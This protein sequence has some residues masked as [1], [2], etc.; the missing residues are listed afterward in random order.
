MVL[1]DPSLLC[2]GLDKLVS[3]T[4]SGNK[5]PSAS[6]RIA[7]FRLERQ[8][9][10]RATAVD[11]EDYA[12]LI[13]GELEAAQLAQPLP[14]QPK[15]A[16]LD[17]HPST[18]DDKDKDRD[19][20]KGK[21]KGKKPCWGWQDGTGCRFGANCLFL[22]A[23]LGP[24]RCWECGSESHLKPQCPLLGQGGRASGGSGGGTTG[25]GKGSGGAAQSANAQNSSTSSTAATTGTAT[26]EKPPRKPKRKGGGKDRGQKDAVRK[27]EEEPLADEARPTTSGGNVEDA[28]ARTEF[29]EE[30][31][32]ALKSLRLAKLTMRSLQ[33]SLGGGGRALIDS[34]ATTS[35]RTAREGEVRGLPLRTV[36]L[37]EGETTFYQLP[38]GTLLTTK[39][40]APIVAMSDL[41]EIGCRVTWCSSE[42]C[43]VVHPVKGDL[44]AR[45]VNGCPEVDE[46]VG[47]KLIE[48][49]ELTKLRRREAELAVNRLVQDCDAL[50][51][52][53]GKL[54]WELGAKAAKDLGNGVGLSW[55][56]LRQAFPEAPSWLV[57]AVPVVAEMDGAGVPWN[58]HERKKWRRAS[59]V[60]VHLFCGRDRST[61]K[62]RA[63]AAHVVLV[64]QAEDVMADA[65]YSALLEL[66]ASGKL[67]T[68]F[69]GPPCRTFSALRN[70]PTAGAGEGPRPLRDREGDGRWG[71]QG[72]TEWETWRVRQDTIMVFRMIFLWMVAAATARANGERDPDFILEHPEDPQTFLKEQNM[73][74]LWAFPEIQFLRDKMKWC[75]WQFDQGPL[76][77]P[78][79]KPTRVLSSM[80]CPRELL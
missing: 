51:C 44:G 73:T 37:A 1:P 42:G 11:I 79:R 71:R 34:G 65:T 12:Y 9:E 46:D 18:V 7:S 66:A 49:A 27:A 19:K 78:R 58:R 33:G 14:S 52:G 35:M 26:E 45:V 64:D 68:V 75:W 22:H 39:V 4:F 59:A 8:L 53:E 70:L 41:M 17:D 31:T 69:G 38:G 80:S 2:R 50:R 77:H 61:W 43:S 32:K 16:R 62:S 15:V 74:S 25:S 5:H 3:A 56:W 63:E 76:G 48:E 67:K 24:G 6:F 28:S 29:F 40:T 47:L 10:Y 57:S 13:L 72:L 36:L 20:G 30:A 55:A 60:A 21:A 23:P 54:D